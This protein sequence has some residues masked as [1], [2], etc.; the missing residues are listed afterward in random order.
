MSQSATLSPNSLKHLVTVLG[1]L[2]FFFL[3]ILLVCF[4]Y[5]VL[6]CSLFSSVS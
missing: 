6:F 1:S 3:C 4:H 5:N 2:F